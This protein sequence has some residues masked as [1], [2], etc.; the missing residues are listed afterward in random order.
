MT[1][2]GWISMPVL[3][4]GPLADQ[5]GQQLKV[6]RPEPV[7]APVAAHRFVARVAQDHLQR[8]ARR[9]VAPEHG[10]D[11]PPPAR[12]IRPWHKQPLFLRETKTSAPLPS[13]Q[14]GARSKRGSTLLFTGEI[15]PSDDFSTLTQCLRPAYFASAEG[16]PSA[17]PCVP[18]RAGLQPM[19]HPLLCRVRAATLLVLH[20][21][22]ILCASP[23]FVNPRRPAKSS[24]ASA[25]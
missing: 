17:L 18:C 3:A 11:V 15:A 24:A 22:S 7:R 23:A 1:A 12:K 5:A 21:C 6:V 2:P 8:A 10:L 25:P 19:T 14:R 9:G 13:V 16:L 4:H 20:L